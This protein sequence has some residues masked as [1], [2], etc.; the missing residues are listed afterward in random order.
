MEKSALSLETVIYDL[1]KIVDIRK[2][3]FA[4]VENISLEE[5]IN[6]IT[7]S[8]SA[9]IRGNN[10]EIIRNLSVPHIKSIKAYINSILYNLISNAIQYRHPERKPIITLSTLSQNGSIILQVQDNGLGIDM[11]AFEKDMF[12]L[13]KRFHTH[14]PGKGL[15]LYLIKQQVEKLSGNITVKSE[16][17]QGTTFTIT[18][19]N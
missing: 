17:N 15:G 5:E 3:K 2:D 7:E 14:V 16:V 11:R 1:G 12:K 6:L 10:V 9:H 19:L 8:L 18:L 4:L 13:Y